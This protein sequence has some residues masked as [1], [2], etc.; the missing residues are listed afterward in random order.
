MSV[1]FRQAVNLFGKHFL[2]GSVLA[3][4]EDVGIGGRYFLHHQAQVLHGWRHA[5]VHFSL[6]GGGFLAVLLGFAVG[7]GK[8][9]DEFGIVERLYHKV[10]S[11]LLDTR[12]R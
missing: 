10:G 7:I 9:V 5:P 6:M 8:R 1:P 3:R 11:A 12:H 4:D 2:A